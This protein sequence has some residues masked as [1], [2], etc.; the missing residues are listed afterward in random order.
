[1]RPW[2]REGPEETTDFRIFR[3]RRFLARSP[4]T[5]HARPFTVLDCA[6]WVNVV[7]LTPAGEL[8][9]VRQFRHG[10]GEETLEVPGGVIDPGESPEHAGARELREETGYAGGAPRLLGTVEPNPAIQS[11]R[12]HTVLL[13][14]CRRVGDA[15]PDPGED[16]ET[17]VLPAD[18]VLA[19]ARD[20]RIRHALVLCALGWWAATRR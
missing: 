10:T 12:C 16:L 6:D 9:L 11:N 1:M 14:G 13:E 18:E 4:R 7:A 2:E 17:V 19:A 3:V 5:G 15:D 8:I 20:G